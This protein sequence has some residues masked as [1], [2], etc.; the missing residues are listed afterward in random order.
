MYC[1][2]VFSR[3]LGTRN[4]VNKYAWKISTQFGKEAAKFTGT[5]MKSVVNIHIMK[6]CHKCV[7]KQKK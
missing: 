1:E 7:S 6:A 4:Y 3:V 5:Q 2:N